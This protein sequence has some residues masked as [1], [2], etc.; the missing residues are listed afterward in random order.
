MLAENYSG[1]QRAGKRQAPGQGGCPLGKER[2]F[3]GVIVLIRETTEYG[4]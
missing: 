3:E 2:F 4:I 1:Q